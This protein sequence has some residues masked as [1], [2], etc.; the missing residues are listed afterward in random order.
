MTS[1]REPL[2]V[3]RRRPAGAAARDGARRE[4]RPEFSDAERRASGPRDTIGVSCAARR[5]RASCAD[6][7]RRGGSA[8]AGVGAEEGADAAADVRID[9]L[10]GDLLADRQLE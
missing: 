7:A 2:V 3:A 1:L 5:A 8:L 10:G 4:T 6:A 9:E